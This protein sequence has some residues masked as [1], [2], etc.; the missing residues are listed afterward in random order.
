VSL[1]GGPA[2]AAVANDG[3]LV[4][5]D[6]DSYPMTRT[7]GHWIRSHA[8]WAKGF[9]WWSRR[10]DGSSA[11]VLF[12]DR[13]GEPARVDHR[14]VVVPSGADPVD[15]AKPEGITL[16]NQVLVDYQTAVMDEE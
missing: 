12:G 2:L 5:C 1:Q 4:H 10:D 11:L 16:L 7:W 14:P 8:D 3:W 9:I 15:F 6:R 13:L